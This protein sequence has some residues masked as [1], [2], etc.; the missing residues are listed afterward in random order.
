M[1]Q[2][3]KNKRGSRELDIDKTYNKNRYFRRTKYERNLR[4]IRIILR[5]RREEIHALGDSIRFDF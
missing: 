4:M 1:H 3:A 2:D 5:N